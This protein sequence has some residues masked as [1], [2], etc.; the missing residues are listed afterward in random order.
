MKTIALLA[1]VPI[2]LLTQGFRG[3]A[4]AQRRG[5]A[6]PMVQQKLQD[7]GVT[8]AMRLVPGSWQ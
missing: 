7:A 6:S 3:A 8:I 2:A 4:P 1:F 5:D